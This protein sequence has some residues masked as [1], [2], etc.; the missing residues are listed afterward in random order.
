VILTQALVQ[1]ACGATA[2]VSAAALPGLQA[3]CDKFEITTG[4]RVAAFLANVGV[5][6]ANLSATVENL[7]YKADSLLATFP[8]HFTQAEAQQY[9]HKPEAIANRAY[10]DRMG[11]GNEASG[12][13]WL[14]R[15]R[16]Y[17][18]STGKR[19]YVLTG[20]G[21]D[22]DLLHHPELLEQPDGAA[23]SAGFFWHNN[24][25]NRY[26]DAGQFLQVCKVINQGSTTAKGSPNGYALRLARFTVAMRQLG[27]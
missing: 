16:G 26:A 18:M 5:E 17:L 19:N 13:G 15:G 25:L 10:A 24:T 4:A 21:I 27:V 9:A 22:M 7:N 23:K 6:S 12:D 3:A 1:A 20:V 14:Y 11:N 2:S 8:S